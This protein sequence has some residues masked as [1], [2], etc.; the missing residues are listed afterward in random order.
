MIFIIG[1]LVGAFFTYLVMD[2]AHDIEWA[3]EHLL[4]K[5]LKTYVTKTGMVLTEADVQRLA[6]EAE[7]GYCVV[8]VDTGE[9]LAR[10]FK[11]LPCP[12]HPDT[13]VYTDPDTPGGA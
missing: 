4:D 7:G 6:D 12:D 11:P 1:M 3:K 2:A 9:V 13:L 10:C 5:P 8:I